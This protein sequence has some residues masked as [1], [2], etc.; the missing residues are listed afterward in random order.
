M[1]GS[2]PFILEA[3]LLI[4]ATAFVTY[5]VLDRRAKSSVRQAQLESERII[6][7][8]DARRRQ[9]AIEAQDE[10]LKLRNDLDRELGQRR[11]EIDRIERRVEQK[12]E[13]IDRKTQSI[14]QREQNLKRQEQSA[15]EVAIGLGRRTDSPTGSPRPRTESPYRGT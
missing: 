4:A 15:P 10:A 1:E 8:A 12:E 2:L 7:E 11:K 5:F 3:I 6:E 13:G 14:D 9:A